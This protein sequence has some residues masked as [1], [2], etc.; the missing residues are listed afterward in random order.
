MAKVISGSGTYVFVKHGIQIDSAYYW[1]ELLVKEL[2]PA[3]WSIADELS[4]FCRAECLNRAW[5]YN[6]I[7]LH[8]CYEFNENG[9]SGWIQELTLSK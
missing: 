3:I 6:L 8:L 9:L 2:L 4:S 1:D 7:T 5:P